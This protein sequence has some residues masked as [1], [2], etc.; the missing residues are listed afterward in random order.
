MVDLISLF[1]CGNCFG[2]EKRPPKY[3]HRKYFTFF[4][5]CIDMSKREV[6][7]KIA[8]NIKNISSLAR[9]FTKYT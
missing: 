7:F 9:N 1:L 3:V 4:E 8:M 5:K 2:N 6:Y